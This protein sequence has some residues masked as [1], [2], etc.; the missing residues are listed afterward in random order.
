MAKDNAGSAVIVS[1]QGSKVLRI[2]GSN[3]VLKLPLVKLPEYP[4][5]HQNPTLITFDLKLDA[6]ASFSVS[7]RS[8]EHS[9]VFASIKPGGA[10]FDHADLATQRGTLKAG[11]WYVVYINFDPGFKGYYISFTGQDGD[12]L[13]YLRRVKTAPYEFSLCFGVTAQAGVVWL[14]NVRGVTGFGIDPKNKKTRSPGNSG[15]EPE[16]IVTTLTLTLAPGSPDLTVR[17]G[18]LLETIKLPAPPSAGNGT[19]LLPANEIFE[20]LGAR[21]QFARATGRLNIQREDGDVQLTVGSPAAVIHGRPKTLSQPVVADHGRVLVPLDLFAG[22][23]ELKLQWAQAENR[24][25][26]STAGQKRE[27]HVPRASKDSSVRLKPIIEGA[28]PPSEPRE[29][30]NLTCTFRNPAGKG[31]GLGWTEMD[32]QE[33]ADWQPAASFADLEKKMV[34]ENRKEVW[35]RF[36]STPTPE[37]YNNTYFTTKLDGT[38]D[39]FNNGVSLR[40]KVTGEGDIWVRFFNSITRNDEPGKA[41]QYGL[42]Y[43]ARGRPQIDLALV[44]EHTAL[45][46]E[47]R[48]AGTSRDKSKLVADRFKVV[49]DIPH[50]RDPEAM[51]GSDG[52]YYLV[53]TPFMHGSIPYARGINDGI[54]L[55][56]SRSRSGPFESMGYVWTFDHAKWANTKYFTADQERNIWA[57]EIAELNGKWYLVYFPTAFPKHGLEGYSVFQIG[58]AVADHPL[59]PYTDTSDQPIVASPDPHLFQDDD[60]AI[61]LTYGNGYIARLKPTMDGLAEAPHFIYPRNAHSVCNEGSTLFKARGKYYFGGAFSNHYFDQRGN[62]IEQSY[63]CELAEADHIYG[64]YGDRFVGLKNAGNN[65]FFKDADGKWYATI[66]QPGKITSIIQVEQDAD[67]KWRPAVDYEVISPEVRY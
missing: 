21:V 30:L 48:D 59:G 3:V 57:P 40:P 15:Y 55:F 10:V 42:H 18:A 56:R 33:T 58:I 24:V 52:Y 4:R 65:S 22:M 14:D 41:T 49:L 46:P 20:A 35:L 27:R 66:W 51:K 8:P 1:E 32:Y 39:A 67:D 13:D 16:A 62:F 54:E 44:R 29:P 25:T 2:A 63:D 34:A 9:V 61:Y 50:I 12:K 60:G 17:S 6:D 37:T 19:V 5:G 7:A 28:T 31:A 36:Q 11:Q 53:G 38:L 43:R 47:L 26:I 45:A 64:P 23:P